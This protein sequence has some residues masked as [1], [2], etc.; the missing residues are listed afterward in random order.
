MR[1][2][3]SPRTRRAPEG[4][5]VRSNSSGA[6]RWL[7]LSRW[8][9]RTGEHLVP[10]TNVEERRSGRRHP[11]AVAALSLGALAASIAALL[12]FL[13]ILGGAD[14]LTGTGNWPRLWFTSSL[15]VWQQYVPD[16]PQGIAVRNVDMFGG[17]T[18]VTIRVGNTGYVVTMVHSK[19]RRRFAP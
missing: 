2:R 11:L 1:P 19:V 5:A 18:A 9:A 13:V 3:K 7:T 10:T 17:M 14:Q 8:P 4:V 16:V 15:R 12:A 6:V